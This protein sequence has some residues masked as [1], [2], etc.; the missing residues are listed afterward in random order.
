MVVNA[1]FIGISVV[2]FKLAMVVL[3]IISM[4]EV[5]FSIHLR[6]GSW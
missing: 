5:G 4:I 6:E 2:L 3:E 1:I